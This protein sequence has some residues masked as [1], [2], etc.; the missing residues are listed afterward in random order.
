M[1]VSK[2]EQARSPARRDDAAAGRRPSGDQPRPSSAPRRPPGRNGVRIAL[3]ALL[4][5]VAL[6]PGA[7]AQ[8]TG[9]PSRLTQVDGVALLPDGRVLTVGLTGQGARERVSAELLDL[10]TGG[11]SRT[12]HFDHDLVWVYSVTPLADGRVLI[13]GTAQGSDGGSGRVAAELF[14]PRSGTFNGTGPMSGARTDHT[15][16]LLADGHVLLAGGVDE[17]GAGE[18]TAS[19]EIFD[20]VT[21]T[22]TS[23]GPMATARSGASATLLRDGRVLVAGGSDSSNDAL[24]SAELYDPRSGTFSETG[25]MSGARM[26]HTATLLA[27][28]NVLLAGGVYEGETSDLAPSAEVFDPVTG[29]FTPTGDMTMT[30]LGAS[31]TLLRDGRVLIAGGS[32]LDESGAIESRYGTT[33]EL[34]DPTTELFTATGSTSNLLRMPEATLLSDGRVLVAGSLDYSGVDF[35]LFEPAAGRFTST[36]VTGISGGTTTLLQDG[37]VLLSAAGP[38]D[39][40]DPT[41]GRFTATGALPALELADRT[42]ATLQDGKVLFLGGWDLERSSPSAELYDPVAATYAPTGW[43]GT[44]RYRPTVTLLANGDVLVTGG[45]QV[46][47][48]SPEPQSLPIRTAELYHPATG[49]FTSTGSLHAGRSGHTATLLRDGRVLIVGGSGGQER[50]KRHASAELYDPATGSFT[51]TGSLHAGRSGHTATLLADGRVLIVGGVDAL[52]RPLRT[53]ELYDPARGRFSRVRSLHAGRSGHTATLLDNSRVLIVGGVDGR[54]RPGRTAELYDPAR[55]RFF[56]TG[57]P[58]TA[59]GAQGPFPPTGSP[60]GVQGAVTATLLRGG[61]VL[62]VGERTA[63]IYDP[64]SGSFAAI[65]PT[66]RQGPPPP[67]APG[68]TS[69]P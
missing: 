22:F 2:R 14:D 50:R 57:S 21:G 9:P 67:T 38:P 55:E 18:V 68:P 44:G 56:A 49:T 40:F 52:D 41:T 48:N 6:A 29:T 39:V 65:L 31:A 3:A 7:T 20:P 62:V 4:S 37:R 23:T 58:P 10:T 16:T 34:Y 32:N 64:A 27:D 25:T 54:G 5:M 45:A 47:W 63:D 8:G 36:G 19:A 24:P 30:R 42:A 26:D 60:P 1:R 53:A 51:P 35:E 13:V 61:R 17:G 12:P 69:A 33:A 15:A 59:R 11:F 43:M 66:T 46:L 28:G